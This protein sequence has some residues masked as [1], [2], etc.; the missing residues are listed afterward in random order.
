L[1]SRLGRLLWVQGQY[2]KTLKACLENAE[3]IA[4]RYKDDKELGRLS[5]TLSDILYENGD[6]QEAEQLAV[7]VLEIG[8]RLNDLELRILA[9]YRLS[10]FESKRGQF[11]KA[12]EWLDRREQWCRELNWSRALAWTLYR[13]GTT[14]IELGNTTIAEAP[15]IQSLDMATSW[16]DRHLIARNQLSLA[17]IYA[18][19]GRL[20]HALQAA[21][22]SCNLFERL[23]MTAK[24]AE[25]NAILQKLQDS[26]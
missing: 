14:L 1:L 20:Q 9:A 11:D 8:E 6:L 5:D 2:D 13:R 23:G 25:A 26:V 3:A 21:E 15:L 10:V 4:L 22:D 24:L 19:T 17:R 7:K 16:N 12:L 18:D